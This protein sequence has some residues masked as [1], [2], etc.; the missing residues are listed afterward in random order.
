VFPAGV[1]IGSLSLLLESTHLQELNQADVRQQCFQQ[2]VNHRHTRCLENQHWL[3]DEDGK[4]DFLIN[5]NNAFDS[6]VDL[7][8]LLINQKDTHHA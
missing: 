7:I 1:Q 2:K 5:I 6:K 4:H 3:K 8:F